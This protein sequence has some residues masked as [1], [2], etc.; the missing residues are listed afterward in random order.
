MD[1]KVKVVSSKY[2]QS[3][4]YFVQRNRSK[5]DGNDSGNSSLT[6]GINSTL[7]QNKYVPN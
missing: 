1:K 6:K 4:E 2:K 5:A 7:S 3:A